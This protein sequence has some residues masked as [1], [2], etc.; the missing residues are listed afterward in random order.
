MEKKIQSVYGISDV[1]LV[2]LFFLRKGFAIALLCMV[3]AIAMFSLMPPVNA[4]RP[5]PDE[6]RGAIAIDGTDAPIGTVIVAKIDGIERGNITTTEP[7]KYGG[8]GTFDERLIVE[9][10]ENEAGHTITFW[11]NGNKA[12]ETATFSGE[13]DS[14]VLDISVTITTGSSNDGS[15]GSETGTDTGTSTGTSNGG[16]S[17]S[18]SG[19]GTGALETTQTTP[20]PTPTPKITPTPTITSEAESGAETETEAIL[21]SPSPSSTPTPATSPAPTPSK[22]GLFEIPGFGFDTLFV[23]LVFALFVIIIK[24]RGKGGTKND[25]E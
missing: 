23:A 3:I 14:R 1:L 21:P 18:S 12:N 13:G 15:S 2:K 20:T 11:I 10:H 16:S 19:D 5:L 4:L 8:P 22:R 25:E 9:G 24:G 6:F 7:G 17:S